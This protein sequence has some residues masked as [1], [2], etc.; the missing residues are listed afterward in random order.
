MTDR[1]LRAPEDLRS[2][3]YDDRGLVPVI[4]QD[5]ADGRVLMLAW[6]NYE[7]LEA[8]LETGEMHFWSRSRE[9]LWRKGETSG[10]VLQVESL[11]TDC[12]ADA[13]LA[14][15]TPTGPACHTGETACFGDGAGPVIAELDGV[16]ADR[17]EKMPKGS[18]TTKLLDDENLR[19]KK[20]GEEAA[21]LVTA[22]AKEDS[23]RSV[24]EAA[25][26]MY[27][28]LAAMRGAGMGW[29]EL[30][31]VLKGRAG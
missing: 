25:D 10:N 30:A 4:A 12:D 19:L 26:L 18:Y 22:L 16:I 2:V 23:E 1:T 15:V 27:H 14:L 29:E 7:A 6:A 5:A 20:I 21:E 13:V 3:E 24:E 17:A 9:E 28:L 31:R 11:H 8:C